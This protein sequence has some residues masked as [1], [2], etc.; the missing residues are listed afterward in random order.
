MEFIQ[1]NL[2]MTERIGVLRSMLIVV[3]RDCPQH[4]PTL[5]DNLFVTV[6]SSP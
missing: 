5:F 6:S 2:E 3:H 1:S 4:K